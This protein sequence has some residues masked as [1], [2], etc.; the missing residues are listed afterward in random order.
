MKGLLIIIFASAIIFA[1][2]LILENYSKDVTATYIASQ[3]KDIAGI[4]LTVLTFW[5]IYCI[6]C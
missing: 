4:V 1:I 5:F 6:V 3:V 2:S